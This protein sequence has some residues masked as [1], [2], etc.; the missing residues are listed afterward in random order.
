MV[1]KIKAIYFSF[2]PTTNGQLLAMII[3]I[4]HKKKNEMD[5]ERFKVIRGATHS[6]FQLY[7]GIKMFMIML[8]ISVVWTDFIVNLKEIII[9]KAKLKL[10]KIIIGKRV[11]TGILMDSI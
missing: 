6:I 1:F 7:D 11:L 4:R 5:T 10:D 9:S 8:M 3:L 2:Y